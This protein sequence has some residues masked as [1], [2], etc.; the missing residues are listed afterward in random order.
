[1]NARSRC[2]VQVNELEGREAP[3]T[4]S[5]PG[6]HPEKVPMTARLLL[7]ESFTAPSCRDHRRV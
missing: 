4:K 7:R 5:E 3:I 6:D 2:G 1:M